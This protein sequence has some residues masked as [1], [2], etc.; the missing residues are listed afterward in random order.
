MSMRIVAGT[1]KGRRILAPKGEGTRPTT[2]RVREALMSSILSAC[3][4]S[5]EGSRVLDAFA[6]T[7][8][9]GLEA[10]SR[11]AAHCIFFETD[12]SAQAVLKRNIESLGIP[13]SMAIVRGT[14]V[15][16]AAK[17]QMVSSIPFD[18]ILLDPPYAYEQ[19]KVESF[20]L[21]LAES[22]NLAQD[23][24]VVYEHKT[25]TFDFSKSTLVSDFESIAHKRYGSTSAMICRYRGGEQQ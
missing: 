12:R 19:E 10:L 13:S 15:F 6:G 11:G 23:A 1:F 16:V 14:D 20:I 4:S 18:L 8:A 2:D 5:L 17:K 3:G 25:G 7:G 24:I 21:A 22:G 9:L